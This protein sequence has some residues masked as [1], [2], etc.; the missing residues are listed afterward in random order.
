MV[1]WNPL[2]VM[3][4]VPVI[5]KNPVGKGETSVFLWPFFVAI[6][7]IFVVW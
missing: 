7:Y 2:K 3:M 5:A 1:A 4:H 6:I